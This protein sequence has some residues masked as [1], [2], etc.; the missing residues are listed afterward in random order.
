MRGARFAS[1]NYS[2]LLSMILTGCYYTFCK[3]PKIIWRKCL[4]GNVSFKEKEER[5]GNRESTIHFPLLIKEKFEDMYVCHRHEHS[6]HFFFVICRIFFVSD[7]SR[8]KLLQQKQHLTMKT[9]ELKT[10]RVGG[11]R[12]CLGRRNTLIE[13][14]K[15]DRIGGLWPG[16]LEREYHLKYK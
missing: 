8:M 1:L 12:G 2:S 13:K 11:K 5:L 7:T 14:G 6:F 4:R 16:N 3:G 9:S 10:Y 15:G